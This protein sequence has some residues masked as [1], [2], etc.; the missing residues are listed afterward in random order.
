MAAK[1]PLENACLDCGYNAVDQTTTLVRIVLP[2]PIN[3][4]NNRKLMDAYYRY[5]KPL[6]IG[7]RHAA[8]DFV[9]ANPR[10]GSPATRIQA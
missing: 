5:A 8:I 2:P 9:R 4:P 7:T 6:F 1:S 3:V 10:P